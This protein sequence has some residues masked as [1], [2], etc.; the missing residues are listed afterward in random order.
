MK[1]NNYMKKFGTFIAKERILVLIIAGL[2]IIPSVYGYVMTRINYDIL[3]YLPEELESMK[4]QDI[5]NDVFHNAATGFIV[6]EDMEDKDV[7]AIKENVAEVDGVDD[8]IWIDDLA[9]ISVPQEILPEDLRELVYKENFTLMMVKFEDAASSDATQDGIDEIRGLIN[10]QCFLSGTAA[11]LKDTIDLSDKEMP[12]YIL[13][14]SIL[15]ILVLTLTLT[16]MVIPYIFMGAI[17]IAILYNMGSNIFLGQIS[18]ITKALAAVLQLGVTMDYSIFL[19]HRYD[20][21]CL[22]QEDRIEAMA[23]AI[24]KTMI[25]IGGSSMTTIAGFMALMVMKLGIGGDLGIVM[26]KGVAIGVISTVT[27]LPALI[28]VFD[29]PIH[30][31]KHKTILPSFEKTSRFITGH[32]K[33]ILILFIILLAPAI[34]GQINAPVYY[35]LDQSMPDDMPSIV[36]LNKLKEEFNMTTTHMILIDDSLP[37]YQKK[38]MIDQ[39]E[40]LDGIVNIAGYD[41]FI[42]P[43]VPESFVPEEIKEIFKKDG[44][45]L[46]LANSNYK[47]ATDEQKNQL[48]EINEIVKAYD[49]NGLITGEG[50]LMKDLVEIADTDFDNVSVVSIFAIFAIIMLIFYSAFIP[51]LLVLAIEIAI[52]INMA[53]PFY[54]GVPI[55]FIASIVIGC[56]QL[57]AT[58]DYA[59]LLTTRY[60]EEIR[61]GYEKHEGM[62]IALQSSIT[63][64]VTSG[65]TFFA[66]TI[67]VAVIAGM[68]LISAIAMMISR[69]ALISMVVIITVLPALLMIS[70]KLTEKTTFHWKQKPMQKKEKEKIL[71]SA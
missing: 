52:F 44:Y 22:V 45:S 21:E 30:K 15:A 58:V 25:S 64:I 16:S 32:Y 23:G 12:Y 57:G 29:K 27:I 37:G 9:D 26:A 31:F 18:H 71:H 68:D 17:G 2:L 40:A 56:I 39:I 63:P 38:E 3:T 10:K 54:T 5:L 4:G 60:R 34:Y 1:G 55:P 70:E 46:L 20:E 59:I 13:V 6:I 65:L 35:N 42:G 19:I 53:I 7:L 49:P 66:A 69:G 14:A 47:A 28:L 8:V 61:N 62:Q 43:A 67:G 11:M 50:A 41:K 48:N 24:S 51:L 36:A 33:G